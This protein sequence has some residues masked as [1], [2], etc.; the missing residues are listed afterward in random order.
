MKL[1]SCLY[2]IDRL[3]GN[4][5]D[6]PPSAP[7][8]G[9]EGRGGLDLLFAMLADGGD[10]GVVSRIALTGPI[11]DYIDRLFELAQVP[12]AGNICR[13]IGGIGRVGHVRLV[14]V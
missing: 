13:V 4:S 11:R 10:G 8:K 14:E 3:Q 9:L 5:L 7:G 12:E 1:H 6:K 2:G